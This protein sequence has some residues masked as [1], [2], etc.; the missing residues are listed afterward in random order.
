MEIE[1]L[2]EQLGK[3]QENINALTI[4]IITANKNVKTHRN[5]M[6]SKKLIINIS[7]IVVLVLTVGCAFY[8]DYISSE[9]LIYIGSVVTAILLGWLFLSKKVKAGFENA[10]LEQETLNK[11]SAELE[12]SKNSIKYQ[13][14]TIEEQQ[15]KT[16]KLEEQKSKELRL[17][18]LEKEKLYN[19]YIEQFKGL[20]NKAIEVEENLI[21]LL[22]ETNKELEKLWDLLTSNQFYPFWEQSLE[23]KR[24]IS[25]YIA[26]FGSLESVSIEYGK[27][28][29]EFSNPAPPFV[30]SD[31]PTAFIEKIEKALVSLTDIEKQ[32]HSQEAFSNA[33]G[34]FKGNQIAMEGF[35]MLN[36]QMQSMSSKLQ[37]TM[38]TLASNISSVSTGI[39]NLSHSI[40]SWQGI[41][42]YNSRMLE[43]GLGSIYDNQAK[44]N[45]ILNN[46]QT[47]GIDLK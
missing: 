45:G 25:N 7:T 2:N 31:V 22:E 4:D 15:Q 8:F 35:N 10:L 24:I 18:E 6:H 12:R 40:E 16:R 26:L 17:K 44:T 34:Q 19:W 27:L 28:S 47:F 20:N 23:V 38:A 33:F 3:V 9:N 1:K 42:E 29:E 5:L 46:I 21:E 37:S 41:N 30:L 13:I 36:N 14:K 11:S 43:S 32:A 39:N